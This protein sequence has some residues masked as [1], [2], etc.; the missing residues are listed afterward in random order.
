[1]FLKALQFQYKIE[2]SLCKITGI[3]WS[4]SSMLILSLQIFCSF[5]YLLFSYFCILYCRTPPLL[6]SFVYLFKG[7]VF[8]R[9]ALRQRVN[10]LIDGFL[11]RWFRTS[12]TY[13]GMERLFVAPSN[14]SLSSFGHQFFAACRSEIQRTNLEI[15]GIGSGKSMQNALVSDVHCLSISLIIK[16]LLCHVI[17]CLY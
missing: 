6:F 14:S 17:F 12:Y 16:Y 13:D 3:L 10:D 5:T 11:K 9:V 7:N 8:K 2:S 1:M 4:H 15:R